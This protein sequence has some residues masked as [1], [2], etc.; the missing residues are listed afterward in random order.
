MSYNLSVG[1][2]RTRDLPV[3]DARALCH[4]VSGFFTTAA[5]ACITRRAQA[6]ASRGTVE[7][8]LGPEGHRW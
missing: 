8:A 5:L 7:P 2:D 6:M 1:E 4:E 3:L